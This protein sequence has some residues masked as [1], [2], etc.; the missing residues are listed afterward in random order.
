MSYRLK[1][2]RKP[3]Q[4]QIRNHLAGL[5]ALANG[6]TPNYEHAKPRKTGTQKETAYDKANAEAA[7][8]LYGATLYRNRRGM[9]QLPGGGVFPYGLGPNGFGDRVGYTP[10]IITLDMVGRK[11]AVFTMVESKTPAGVVSDEQLKC[12]E[13]V[14][15]A[16]GIAG[17]A[18]GP[19][20]VVLIY[21][22]WRKRA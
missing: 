9:V 18:R 20:D 14:R 5:D 16:G 12:I 21:Q 3:S 10:I 17:V 4:R 8:A 6:T 13:E 1:I 22:G 7:A 15:D 19:D 2:P 11:I